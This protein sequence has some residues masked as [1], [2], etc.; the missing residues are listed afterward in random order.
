[1]VAAPPLCC[2]IARVRRG[3][4]SS[5]VVIVLV[6]VTT[7][8]AHGGALDRVDRFRQL[9]A[10]RLGPA[11][12]GDVESVPDAYREMY[13]LLDEEIVDNLG[14]GGL[15]AS[16]AFLQERLDGFA[17][18]WGGASFRLTRLGRLVVGAF[19]LSDGPHG[20]SVRVYGPLH[21]EAALLTTLHRDGRPTVHALPAAA[22]RAEF[23]VTWEGSPSG[24]GTRALRLDLVRQHGDGVAVVWSTADLFPD[25][26]VAR[27]YRVRGGEVRIRYELHYA[28]WTPGCDQQTEQEDVYRLAPATGTFSRV[29]RVQH[30]GWHL[31]F[32]RVVRRFFEALAAVDASAL[33]AF[34]PSRALR[35]RL[36]ATLQA[37]PACDAADAP[38]PA[39]VSVA[40]IEG[41]KR[42]WTLTWQRAGSHWLLVAA[43]PV[44]P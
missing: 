2:T 41:E 16:T 36:P 23:V 27:D 19:A 30:D 38:N 43:A 22:G 11:Q 34:V 18:V 21:G 29:S 37:E 24:R 42:P 10:T 12:L 7:G 31:A 4:G 28:G 15:F 3:L 13:A 9:A 35:D 40:A 25:G 26:L 14:S 39:H 8:V 44:V 6:L 1:M 17:D 32:H 5:L 33:G 20:N